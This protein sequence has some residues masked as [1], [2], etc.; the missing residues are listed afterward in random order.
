[1]GSHYGNEGVVKIGANVVAELQGFVYNEE[2]D[3]AE[4]WAAGDTKK[5]HKAGPRDG[6]LEA[7]VQWDEMDT[8]GQGALVPGASV[9]IGAY[10]EGATAGDVYY[11]GT[12]LVKSLQ[13][14]H[15][16]DGMVMARMRTLGALD[17]QTAV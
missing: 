7:E 8:T 2:V 15:R 11:G 1:M 17:K 14:T 16:K 9:T 10:P 12:V 5:E 13:V 3:S 6:V 4:D